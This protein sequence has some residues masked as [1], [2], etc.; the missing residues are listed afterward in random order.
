MFIFDIFVNVDIN[1]CTPYFLKGILHKVFLFSLK[2]LQNLF[3]T[4]QDGFITNNSTF[5]NGM[6]LKL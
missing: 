4:L 6:F 3:L 2:R 5:L 1:L